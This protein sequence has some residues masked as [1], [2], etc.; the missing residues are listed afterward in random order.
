MGIQTARTKALTFLASKH[1]EE[2][3][4]IYTKLKEDS[5]EPIYGKSSTAYCVRSKLFSRAKVIL[6]NR[7][8]GEFKELYELAV[9]QGF[10]R[11]YYTQ[12]EVHDK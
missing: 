2:L 1:K 3:T 11:G 9:S 4:E 5:I 6:K 8:V 10:P 7:H 12:K